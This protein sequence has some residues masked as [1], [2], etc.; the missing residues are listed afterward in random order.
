VRDGTRPLGDPCSEPLTG[1][2]DDGERRLDDLL[3]VDIRQAPEVPWDC[4]LGAVSGS[5]GGL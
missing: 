3:L 1:V 2:E 5:I 4:V